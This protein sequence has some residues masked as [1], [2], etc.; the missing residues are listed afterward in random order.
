MP[1]K[2]KQEIEI[3]YGENTNFEKAFEKKIQT[4]RVNTSVYFYC[5][6][7]LLFVTRA[8][9]VSLQAFGGN[10]KKQKN[11]KRVVMTSSHAHFPTLP[12]RARQG[13]RARARARAPSMA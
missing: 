7:F 11:V 9:N 5:F 4:T 13:A 8:C 1:D 10:R 12:T 6:I 2:Y 3:K